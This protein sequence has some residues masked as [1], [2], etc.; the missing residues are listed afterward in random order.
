[1][2]KNNY[3][4]RGNNIYISFMWILNF[5][6]SVTSWIYHKFS[7]FVLHLLTGISCYRMHLDLLVQFIIFRDCRLL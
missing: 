3:E 1:M 5:V 6:T 4:E 2:Y 7:K